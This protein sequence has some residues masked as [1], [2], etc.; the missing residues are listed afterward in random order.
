ME[1]L[2]NY[3]A[4]LGAVIANMVIGT[5][6]YGPVF[7]KVWMRMTGITAEGMKSMKLS[8]PQAMLGML[9]LAFLM[10]YVLAHAIVFG[11][12]YTQ[13]YGA[14]GGMTGA[15][16]YWLGFAVP[17]TAGSFLWEGKSWKLWILNAGYY[18]V[19]LLLAGAI[20]GTFPA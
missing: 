5:L 11:S 14:V 18:L 12:A 19:T 20:L 13:I 1:I 6:W 7:G 8:G 16:Y 10:N 3:W 15:F 17:L 9:V 4:V 2:I